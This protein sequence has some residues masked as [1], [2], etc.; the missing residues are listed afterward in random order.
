MK[1]KTS[2]SKNIQNAIE[3]L[4]K[5]YENIL[6]F[7]IELE[8]EIKEKNKEVECMRL[9][10][11]SGNMYTTNAKTLIK[12]DLIL[13]YGKYEKVTDKTEESK[14]Q[15]SFKELKNAKELAVIEIIL[16]GE[17]KQIEIE[18]K[19]IELPAVI[20]GKIKYKDK[21]AI[22]TGDSKKASLYQ[23]YITGKEQIEIKA[24]PLEKV[25]KETCKKIIE[26][27]ENIKL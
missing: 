16:G 4:E 25:T 1:G 14:E 8:K 22:G 26:E 11:N 24:I 20:Y 6:K 9:R 12:T 19:Q 7:M 17:E 18:K 13:A 23:S 15:K 3:I 21:Q 27:I 10:D 2:I 5:T